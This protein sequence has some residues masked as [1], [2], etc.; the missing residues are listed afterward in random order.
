MHPRTASRTK[1][2][3]LISFC[4]FCMRGICDHPSSLDFHTQQL[5][6][7]ICED[8][9]EH[10]QDISGR[11]SDAIFIAAETALE[12]KSDHRVQ[13]SGRASLQPAEHIRIREAL[14]PPDPAKHEQDGQASEHIRY[15]DPPPLLKGRCAID[16]GRLVIFD[17]DRL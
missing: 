13:R 12:D 7:E 14:Q 8:K 9:N 16:R 10:E 17:R 15:R 11:R 1:I 4:R 6:I 5:G 3:A 2:T